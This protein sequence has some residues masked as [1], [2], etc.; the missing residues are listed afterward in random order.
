MN[1]SSPRFWLAVRVLPLLLLAACG[2]TPVSNHYLLTATGSQ[3]P[4]GNT[5]AVGIG[6]VTVSEYLNRNALVQRGSGNQLLVSTTERWAEPLED[7]IVR[8]VGLNLATL[9]Q[10]RNMRR[11]PWHPARAP[12]YGVKLGI[13]EMDADPEHVNLVVDWLVY[14]AGDASAVERQLSRQQAPLPPTDNAD[15]NAVVGIYSELLLKLSEDIAAAIR[16][17]QTAADP[18]AIPGQ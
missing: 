4:T 18:A 16:R 13:L 12:D 1:G 10:T 2:S 3:P 17:A 7:G 8:V 5:P 11:Y 15:S 6:P 14:R 9:L